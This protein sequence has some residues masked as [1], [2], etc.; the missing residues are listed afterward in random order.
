MQR[1]IAKLVQNKRMLDLNKAQRTRHTQEQRILYSGFR[2]VSHN[3][4]C[5]D[6]KEHLHTPGRSSKFYSQKN[7]E[8]GK[9]H[10]HW[11]GINLNYMDHFIWYQSFLIANSRPP[12]NH[13]PIQQKA[14]RAITKEILTQLKAS[15]KHYPA[16]LKIEFNHALNAILR[17]LDE[18]L[19]WHLP[20]EEKTRL[21]DH[22]AQHIQRLSTYASMAHRLIGQYQQQM[23][24]FLRTSWTAFSRVGIA[25][26]RHGSGTSADELFIP[27]TEQSLVYWNSWAPNDT[28]AWTPRA[29]IFNRLLRADHLY[30]LPLTVIGLS[31]TA[32]TPYCHSREKGAQP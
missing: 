10:L 4:F 1:R 27:I 6:F 15:W 9:K 19:D 12:L 11:N 2:L 32:W 31:C 18:V 29:T 22:D 14:D 13:W 28:T 5:I 24:A 20:I 8:N 3:L 23:V 30:T 25:D 26:Y 7:G 16:K 21:I 17:Y